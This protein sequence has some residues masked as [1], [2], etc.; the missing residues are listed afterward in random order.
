MEQLNEV[1]NDEVITIEVPR[2]RIVTVSA[3]IT[4]DEFEALQAVS[5]DCGVSRSSLI[6]AALQAALA[7]LAAAGVSGARAQST[8]KDALASLVDACAKRAVPK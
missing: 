8:G 2:S 3:K 4:Y 6:R 1:L 5:R 7:Q